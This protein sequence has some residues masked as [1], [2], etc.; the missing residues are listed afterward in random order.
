MLWMDSRF[1][2]VLTQLWIE[3]RLTNSQWNEGST[4][5]HFRTQNPSSLSLYTSLTFSVARGHSH[6]SECETSRLGTPIVLTE[7]LTESGLSRM[8]GLIS[9]SHTL[10]L[11]QAR[12]HTQGRLPLERK[13]GSA[14]AHYTTR[15]LSFWTAQTDYQLESIRRALAGK[16]VDKVVVTRKLC[17]GLISIPYRCTHKL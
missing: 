2:T 4:L 3:S 16:K 5:S 15:R 6:P 12:A 7:V 10:S 8:R 14:A 17:W 1:E 13:N 11:S 9:P